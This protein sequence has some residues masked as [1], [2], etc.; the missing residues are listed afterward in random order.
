MGAAV[1]YCE[2]SASLF[3]FRLNESTLRAPQN[4]TNKSR[5]GKYHSVSQAGA[6][7]PVG[8][9]PPDSGQR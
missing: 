2:L 9:N 8:S 6:V 7:G 4:S 5:I 3:Q 1:V